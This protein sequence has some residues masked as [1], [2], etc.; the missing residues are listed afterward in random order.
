MIIDPITYNKLSQHL[1]DIFIHN[2]GMDNPILD[3][4]LATPPESPTNG[5]RYIVGDSAT[6]SWSGHENEFSQ[7]N[8]A[9][10][11]WKFSTPSQ[12]TL[13]YIQD[14]DAVYKYDAT[15]KWQVHYR[16]WSAQYDPAVSI[17]P[18]MASNSQD[19]FVITSSSENGTNYGWK[20]FDTDKVTSKWEATSDTAWLQIL[21]DEDTPIGGV[22]LTVG[23]ARTVLAKVIGIYYDYEGEGDEEVELDTVYFSSSISGY[24][25]NAALENKSIPGAGIQYKGIRIEF[26][27]TGGNVEVPSIIIYPPNGQVMTHGFFGSN[28]QYADTWLQDIYLPTDEIAHKLLKKRANTFNTG[29]LEKT[30]IHRNDLLIMEDSEKGFIK[31]KVKAS[32]V[33]P[34]YQVY[35][36]YDIDAGAWAEDETAPPE[37]ELVV[38]SNA[39][40]EM[41]WFDKVPSEYIHKA[42]K[43]PSD[44]DPDGTV[45]IEVN[46]HSRAA[47]GGEIK[48]RLDHIAKAEGEDIDGTPYT[49]SDSVDKTTDAQLNEIDLITWSPTVATLGWAAND[50][51]LLRLSMQAPAGT[52]V[53]GDY[54]AKHVRIK[55]PRKPN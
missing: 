36:V 11:E 29:F 39:K 8:A 17:V 31:K 19:G 55:V 10:S 45:I 6:D 13:V 52:Q 16:N 14:E 7:Y 48:V 38:G 44:I 22:L 51:V 25:I 37:Y 18:I 20:A 15:N 5:D 43:M 33:A 4:D 35:A 34:G 28:I 27:R 46:G 41:Y 47:D 54:G 12:D 3:K 40:Y 23:G 42:I 24:A 49:A 26:E 1:K 53:D 30:T 2:K 21:F 50:I 32:T 9:A